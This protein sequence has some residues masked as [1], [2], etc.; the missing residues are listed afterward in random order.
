M[1]TLVETNKGTFLVENNEQNGGVIIS[2]ITAT[3]R[4]SVLPNVEWRDKDAIINAIEK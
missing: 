1:A 3:E 4:V 2:K